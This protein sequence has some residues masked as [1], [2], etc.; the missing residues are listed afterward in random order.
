[1]TSSQSLDI[2]GDNLKLNLKTYLESFR[3]INDSY[4]IMD[5][6]VHNFGLKI[7]VVAIPGVQK[8]V[9]VQSIITNVK[10]L[11]DVRKFHINQPISLGDISYAVMS[12]D[13]VASIH[14]NSGSN[15][16]VPGISVVSKTEAE[17]DGV[18]SYTYDLS[19]PFDIIVEKGYIFPKRNGI[20]E[21]K[22]PD[23]DI[24]VS[25]R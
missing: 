19:Q 4:I 21:M 10:K 6:A 2:A 3:L 22:Y 8:S 14:D 24:R 17:S 5:A 1:M 11:L 12:S 9:V 16:R 20:F 15:L 13:G 7:N 23:F 25:V 18:N